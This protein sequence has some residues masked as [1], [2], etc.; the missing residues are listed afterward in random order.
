MSTYGWPEQATK[1]LTKAVPTVKNG[2]VIKWEVEMRY[3]LNGYQSTMRHEINVPSLNKT[4]GAWTRTELLA[5]C[6]TAQW[7]RVFD[8]QYQSVMVDSLTAPTRDD[9][10]D[11]TTMPEV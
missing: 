11:V 6:P 10:F 1:V 4:P 7:D 8:S 2:N 3:M 9:T 5:E